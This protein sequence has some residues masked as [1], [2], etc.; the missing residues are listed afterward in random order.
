MDPQVALYF[1]NEFREARDGALKDAEGYQQILFALERLGAYM[2]EGGCCE[3]RE[4][5]EEKCC[6]G[7]KDKEAKG[8][9]AYKE[10]LIALVKKHH[11]LEKH[12]KNKPK[13][14]SLYRDSHTAFGSL[15]EMVM[16]G[17][18][19]ALHQGAFARTLTLHLVEVALFLEDTLMAI[20]DRNITDYMV[21]NPVYAYAW[22]PVSFVRQMMLA[23]SFSYIP[24]YVKKKE[25][26]EKKAW[27]IIADYHIAEYLQSADS[28]GRGKL[29]AQSI[30]KAIGSTIVEA[31][32]CRP[33]D[34]VKAV[35]ERI[36]GKPILVVNPN[37]CE[38]LLGIATA[39]DLM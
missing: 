3:E 33:D 26:P 13:W 36:K 11:P 30:E 12:R 31:T 29:L 10:C 39:F 2:F 16:R 24:V 28:D 21:R 27:H 37:N 15:Y 19:D 32:T 17:R 25:A 6:E 38:E 1:R 22:Q 5:Q 34:T 7:N 4:L 9:D 20:T 8:L 35:L 14:T 23:N 18:N